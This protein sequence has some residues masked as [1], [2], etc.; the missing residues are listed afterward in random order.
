M[1]KKAGI[2]TFHNYNNYGAILQSYALHRYLKQLGAD[3][4][5]I[6]YNCSYISNPFSLKR[7]QNKGLFEY[8]YGALGYLFYLPRRKKC[9]QFRKNMT[10]SRPVTRKNVKTLDGSYDII[11]AGSDQI[12]NH[13]LTN[14]DKTYFLDFVTKGKKCSYAASLGEHLPDAENQKDYQQ[15]LSSFDQILVRESY[16]ADAVEQ[17][18]RKRPECSCDPTF[19]LTRSEWEELLP[20]TSTKKPYILAYQLGVN[21]G[22]VKF[23]KRMKKQTGLPVSYIPFP[24]VGLLPCRTNLWAG[25]IEW[26]CR[27]RDAEYIITD[28]FHGVVFALLFQ[29]RFFV[30]TDGHHKNKRVRELLE[31]LGLT[32]RIITGDLS[33]QQLTENMDYT[34]PEQIIQSMR[35][36]S[37][38]K[39]KQMLS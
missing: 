12:W 19:L 22:F 3:P 5:I 21:P 2:L 26:L 13:N 34:V 36:D 24:L 15:L 8:L 23:V 28:S 10:Y 1:M 16:G 9:N 30:L 38:K 39:L 7:L 11:I 33:D 18:I 32:N 6:D 17:L 14:F 25:P 35:K 20:P 29:K 31:R 4:E 37:I 27:F